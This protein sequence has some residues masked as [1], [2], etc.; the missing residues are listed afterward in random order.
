M[1]KRPGAGGGQTVDGAAVVVAVTP[2]RPLD[3]A[4]ARDW[5]RWLARYTRLYDSG[6]FPLAD[7]CKIA[8]V[9]R[10]GAQ[11]C[12]NA[13]LEDIKAQLDELEGVNGERHRRLTGANPSH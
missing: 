9:A 8:F 2:F 6:R 12:D 11:M 7:L 10:V 3:L 5:R 4:T 1:P 13:D